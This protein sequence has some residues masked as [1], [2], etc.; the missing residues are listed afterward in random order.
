LNAFFI[1]FYS[2]FLTLYP[3]YKKNASIPL[4]RMTAFYLYVV[5]GLTLLGYI[6]TDFYA[7]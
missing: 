7:K 4:S 5:I 6:A 1:L 2:L 3:N